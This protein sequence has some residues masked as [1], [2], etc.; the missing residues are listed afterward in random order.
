VTKP[1]EL[2]AVK[3]TRLVAAILG[4]PLIS[5]LVAR[6]SPDGRLVALNVIGVLPLAVSVLLNATPT[7][8][9]KELV[10]VMTRG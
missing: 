1:Y 9:L 2:D 10:E 8:P 7:V 4:V 5:P 3:I 6:V